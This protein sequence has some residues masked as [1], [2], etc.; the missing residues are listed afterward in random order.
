MSAT[1]TGA[2][3]AHIHCARACFYAYIALGA[4]CGYNL[5]ISKE[6]RDWRPIRPCGTKAAT[7]ESA[8]FCFVAPFMAAHSR[9]LTAR[10]LLL[11]R[12]T[13]TPTRLGC[14]PDWRLEGSFTTDPLEPTM[15]I[16]TQTRALVPVSTNTTYYGGPLL[17]FEATEDALVSAGLLE[18]EEAPKP[19]PRTRREFRLGN[20]LVTTY[21]LPDGRIRLHISAHLARMRDFRFVSFMAALTVPTALQGGMA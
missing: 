13:G 15:A 6:I 19:A 1:N 3:Y 20:D 17:V 2:A 9:S 5:F 14:R 18:P 7:D 8:V 16:K 10:Q 4:G 12:V 11:R 21:R